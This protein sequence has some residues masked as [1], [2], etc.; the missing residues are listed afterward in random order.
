M[1]WGSF[2]TVFGLSTFKFMF[3][4]LTGKGLSLPFWETVIACWLGGTFS[5]A[6]F[7][8]ASE[9]VSNFS[10]K[11]RETKEKE[12]FTKTGV[13]AAPPRHFTKMN[14]FIIRMKRSMGIYGI[15]FWAPFFLSV[16]IGSVVVAKFY[17][18]ERRAFPLIAF[19]MAINA[20]S[21]SLLT[22]WVF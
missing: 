18:N 22:Y 6:I 1:A 10:K 16:P 13:K 17:G 3:A 5:A 15:C 9:L 11:R 14:R 20:L 8:Y 2:L 4:P 7:F 12:V 19:G 21:M